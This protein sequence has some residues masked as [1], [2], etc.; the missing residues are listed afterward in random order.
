MYGSEV[1]IMKYVVRGS[2]YANENHFD[3]IATTSCGS[4]DARHVSHRWE[5]SRE[6]LVLE[7]AGLIYQRRNSAG[8]VAA[9]FIFS[10]NTFI[11]NTNHVII[12]PDT[13][14]TIN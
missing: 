10:F 8:M 12:K 4:P 9:C 7:S 5:V 3:F 6:L 14:R 1:F 13:S 11:S 2:R